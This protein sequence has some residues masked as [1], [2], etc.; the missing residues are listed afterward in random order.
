MVRASFAGFS[1]ALSAIQASQKRLDITGQNLA[2]MNTPGYTRQQLEV[3]SVTYT[4]PVSHYMNGSEV[5]VGYG[6]HMDK[7]SQIR[8]PY[9]D[10]QYRSQMRKSGY[11]DSMQTSLDRL[12]SFLDES[13]VNGIHSAF[14]DIRAT[15]QNMQDLGKVN[16]PVFEAQL[17]SRMQALTNLLNDAD[18]QIT[19]A[20]QE[21]FTR[22]DGTGTNENGAVQEVNDILRQIG[23]LNRQIKENQ[24]FGQQSL[25]LMDERNLLLDKLSSYIPIEVTYYKDPDHDGI[26]N[27]TANTVDKD[28][29]YD[30]DYMGNIIGRQDW[31]DDLRVEMVYQDENGVTQKLTLV[32]GTI[33]AGEANFGQLEITNGSLE[34]PTAAEITFTGA[35]TWDKQNNGTAQAAVSVVFGKDAAG[36]VTNQ[37]PSDSG[38]IQA[39]LDMLWKDG[40]TAGSSDVNGYEFYR[41]QLN[42]LARS[43]AHV[44]NTINI[45]G[46]QNKTNPPP[47]E[48]FLLANKDDMSKDGITAGNI[49]INDAWSSGAVHVGNEGSSLSDTVL[50]LLEAM[51]TTYP[52]NPAKP[53]IG[54]N[55]NLLF[56]QTQVDLENNSFA[57]FMNHVS[58]LLANDSYTNTNALKSNV[59]V[60]NGIQNSRDSISGISLDEEASNMMVY[61]SAYN[62]ASRL[63]TALDE[64]LN[65]LINNTGLVGR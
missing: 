60:L 59:I 63:M 29:L 23:L 20:E 62:A 54:G 14:D 40:K 2:N 27:G 56:D 12:S 28:E 65:T 24:I 42:N 46:N 22:L 26:K 64:A 13:H 21:E 47:D 1:T 49:G 37:F 41:N 53:G 11:T 34:D 44:I 48:W 52:M 5:M 45:Q 57:D 55:N 6:V 43:F 32:E 9:L 10:A 35:S 36:K 58:T 8:D 16:D 19:K 4:H 61:M 50:N 3:S 15:L 51:G 39:S 25:E 38:S 17:R 31:P 33:G 18:R 30:H 7:V